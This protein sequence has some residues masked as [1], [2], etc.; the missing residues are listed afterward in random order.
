MFANSSNLFA[1]HERM[2]SSSSSSALISGLALFSLSYCFFC[3][4]PP[5]KRADWALE[6]ACSVC[7]KLRFFA[8]SKLRA[9][10]ITP[11][12][13]VLASNV[14][15]GR[16]YV[17]EGII[18]GEYW[19]SPVEWV[20]SS[21]SSSWR[22]RLSS[23]AAE[24]AASSGWER[25]G[26][27]VLLMYKASNS[28]WADDILGNNVECRC[29]YNKYGV[30]EWAAPRTVMFQN[31][32]PKVARWR[33]RIGWDRKGGKNNNNNEFFYFFFYLYIYLFFSVWRYSWIC[34][35]RC[36]VDFVAVD[37]RSYQIN[38][39]SKM[40][41]VWGE[42]VVMKKKIDLFKGWRRSRILSR[43]KDK[44]ETWDKIESIFYLGLVGRNSGK[45]TEI[46][47]SSWPTGIKTGMIS[48]TPVRLG[49]M[50]QSASV[51]CYEACADGVTTEW[52]RGFPVPITYQK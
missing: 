18:E 28:A 23:E 41:R 19:C 1:L 51:V 6:K 11:L 27:F 5:S 49:K 3:L 50:S 31:I 16:V 29:A 20:W 45:G 46:A 7:R 4:L 12:G 48:P 42:R 15:A 8:V 37:V 52:T 14:W 25:V 47:L 24:E 9:S 44:D 21:S 34:C 32:H 30:E 38:E 10:A 33:D 40:E 13:P 39:R 35:C 26:S 2:N 43:R 36:F 17:A 22:V